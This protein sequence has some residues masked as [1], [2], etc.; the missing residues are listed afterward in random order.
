MPVGVKSFRSRY[1]AA[2]VWNTISSIFFQGGTLVAN[3]VV[4]K[5]IGKELFGE[6]GLVLSTILT[7][8]VLSQIG[9]GIA[10]TKYVAQYKTQDKIR[11]GQI[12]GLCAVVSLVGGIISSFLLLVTSAWIAN[13]FFGDS[14][15]YFSIC[16][17]IHGD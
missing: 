10:A 11:A 12:L 17:A 14:H 5:I 3:I 16:S 2:V 6:Y 4:A 15:M 1:G 13:S 8:A 9:T 7:V